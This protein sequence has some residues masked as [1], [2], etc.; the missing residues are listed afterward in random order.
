MCSQTRPHSAIAAITGARKSFGCG[1]VKRMRSMPVDCVAG[2]QQLAESVRMSGRRS[3]PY[4]FTF[5]PSS[6][7]S[8]TP[9]R[10]GPLDLGDDLAGPAAL[11]LA[12]HRRHDAVRADRVAAH[13]DLHPGLEARARG[14]SGS[15]PAKSLLHRP[16]RPRGRRPRRRR[17]A[18]RPGAGS[19]PARRR[20]PR[21]GRARRGARAAPPRSS[22]RRR[23]RCSGI[24]LLQRA[25]L[26][27]VRGEALVRLLAD[28]AGVEDDHVGLV[29]ARPPPPARATR[30]CP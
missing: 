27:E 12:A 25:R 1:L 24:A 29:L 3:R 8:R 2:T 20:R 4:E 16:K 10:R 5:W 14:A 26:R 7:T 17:R 19:S 6:V 11:L 15:S 28:R 30:A 18:T 9:S 22:R 13:R 23:S 21:T